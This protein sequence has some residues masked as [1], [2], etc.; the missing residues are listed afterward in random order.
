[1]FAEATLKGL[2]DER[3]WRYDNTTFRLKMLRVDAA[4]V[5]S[6]WRCQ[7]TCRAHAAPLRRAFRLGIHM[8][9][10]EWTNLATFIKNAAGDAAVE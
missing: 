10:C 8:P 7:K 1:M 3:I 2:V 5:C 6:P 9:G 4:A